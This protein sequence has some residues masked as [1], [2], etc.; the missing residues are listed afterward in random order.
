MIKSDMPMKNKSSIK[1][2]ELSRTPEPKKYEQWSRLVFGY[3]G[4]SSQLPSSD[5]DR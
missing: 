4:K 2:E 3:L 5:E 1:Y